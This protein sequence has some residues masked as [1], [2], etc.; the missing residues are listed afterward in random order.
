M[1]CDVTLAPSASAEDHS[2]ISPIVKTRQL[3]SLAAAQ[4]APDAAKGDYAADY[5]K[6]V[7]AMGQAAMRSWSI[8]SVARWRRNAVATR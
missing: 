2:A 6:L 5:M 8:T 3:R 4:L 7:G 1:G